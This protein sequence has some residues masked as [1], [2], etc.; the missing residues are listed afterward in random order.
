MNVVEQI[1]SGKFNNTV[2]CT[3][4]DER[5]RYR[6]ENARIK[7]AFEVECAAQFGLLKHP[8]RALQRLLRSAYAVRRACKS[9]EKHRDA[10]RQLRTHQACGTHVAMDFEGRERPRGPR[11]C[12]PSKS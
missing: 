4:R 2:P 10:D 1:Q 3:T 11:Q 9:R 5:V 7:I 8:K 12:S 6:E